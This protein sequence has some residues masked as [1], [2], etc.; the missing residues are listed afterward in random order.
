MTH[1]RTC[2]SPRRVN[3]RA[4]VFDLARGQWHHEPMPPPSKRARRGCATSSRTRGEDWQSQLR[5]EERRCRRT[6]RPLA[7][8]TEWPHAERGPEPDGPAPLPCEAG[9]LLSDLWVY[10]A[11]ASITRHGRRRRTPLQSR[12]CLRRRQRRRHRPRRR[13]LHGPRGLRRHRLH[14][15]LLHR[16]LLHR[17]RRR[18]L[19]SSSP[20]RGV[21]ATPDLPT[22][23]QPTV[24]PPRSRCRRGPAATAQTN[25]AA[26]RPA[27]TP[28][29]SPRTPRRRVVT[30]ARRAWCMG[31]RRGW[32]TRRSSSPLTP[33]GSDTPA[34]ST[35]TRVCC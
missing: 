19:G 30:L 4:V 21:T 11:T 33:G 15:R 20:R 34:P 5:T 27:T 35:V 9:R 14:R 26:L 1:T 18:G 23:P 10:N 22:P 8:P 25:R 16:R 12:P 6:A 32:H 3:R 2:L 28:A 17:S 13:R 29:R 31:R 7:E 24:P